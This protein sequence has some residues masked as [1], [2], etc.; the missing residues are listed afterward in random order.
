M[1][2]PG[3]LQNL[4]EAAWDSPNTSILRKAQKEEPAGDLKKQTESLCLPVCYEGGPYGSW[5]CSHVD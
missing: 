3:C 2:S 5:V 4:E 1:G